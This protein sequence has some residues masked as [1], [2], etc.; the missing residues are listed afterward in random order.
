[1]GTS[2]DSG[3]LVRVKGSDLIEGFFERGLNLSR[4]IRG[5]YAQSFELKPLELDLQSG[6]GPALC[7]DVVEKPVCP[8]SLGL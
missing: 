5:L 3:L 6:T 4:A 2:S 1:M 7:N 8:H